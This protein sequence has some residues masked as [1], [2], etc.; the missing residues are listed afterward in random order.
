MSQSADDFLADVI[1]QAGG[2][3]GRVTMAPAWNGTIVGD[4]PTTISR[5]GAHLGELPG[6]AQSPVEALSTDL[7]AQTGVFQQAADA[8]AEKENQFLTVYA[9]A[10]RDVQHQEEKIP[11]TLI[12]KHVETRVPVVAAKC[13]WNTAKVTKEVAK[14]K[15]DELQNRLVAA[16]SNQRFIREQS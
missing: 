3:G 10:F 9:L 11:A 6:R 5:P 2:P 15:W 1:P 12:P 4:G 13:E 16:M 14:R 8:E 7:E